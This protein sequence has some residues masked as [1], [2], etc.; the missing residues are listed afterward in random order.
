MT[1][2]QDRDMRGGF[3]AFYLQNSP[4]QTKTS[5]TITTLSKGKLHEVG[6]LKCQPT[7]QPTSLPTG[8]DKNA[9]GEPIQTHKI[10]PANGS[11][12]HHRG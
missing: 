9:S 3:P 10:P 6:F 7:E 8:Y 4:G 5:C 11:M 1:P 12:V 2:M